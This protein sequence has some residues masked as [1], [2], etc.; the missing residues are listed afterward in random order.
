MRYQKAYAYNGKNFRP[1]EA[2]QQVERW[3]GLQPI[4]FQVTATPFVRSVRFLAVIASL[5]VFIV[6]IA[7]YFT[8]TLA[9]T[10]KQVTVEITRA[11]VARLKYDNSVP[12]FTTNL[13]YSYT[14]DG[15]LYEGTRLSVAPTRSRSPGEIKKLLASFWQGRQVLAYVNPQKPGQAYLTTNPDYYLMNFILPALIVLTINWLIGQLQ[16]VREERRRRKNWRFGEL[17]PA[18]RP[19]VI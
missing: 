2:D 14:I 15:Q 4:H 13:A 7:H 8:A 19:A 5:L 10:W 11:E 6:G 1:Q 16:V 17:Q 9:T 12:L 18:Y 3:Q